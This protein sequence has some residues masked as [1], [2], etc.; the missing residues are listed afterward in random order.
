MANIGVIVLDTAKICA[1]PKL[2]STRL[3]I[4]DNIGEAIHIH[5]RNLRLDFT[6]RDFLSLAKVCEEAKKNIDT[7]THRISKATSTKNK[8]NESPKINL[9]KINW[10][11]GNNLEI[12]LDPIFVSY[13]FCYNC[14][15]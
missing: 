15:W 14:L 9:P 13:G 6:I 8:T 1:Q 7:H 3:Q 5:W 2:C 11:A 12:Q 10:P 4:E